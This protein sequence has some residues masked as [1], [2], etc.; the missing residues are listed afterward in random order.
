MMKLSNRFSNPTSLL[1]EFDQFFDRAFRRPLHAGRQSNLGVYEAD[2]AWH[3]R[4]DLPGFT[5]EELNLTFDKGVLFLVA[6][7]KEGDNHPF[8]SRIERTFRTPKN[9]NPE[10]ITARL[11]AGV[12][13]MILPKVAPETPERLEIK[14]D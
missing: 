12:L 10:G 7:R 1:S 8:Q 6:E 4:T 3:L 9:V 5:K 11:E 2:D 14:I 13:E